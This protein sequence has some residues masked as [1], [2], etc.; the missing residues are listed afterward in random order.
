MTEKEIKRKEYLKAY[1]QANREKMLQQASEYQKTKTQ[2][3]QTKVY[4]E[5]TKHKR[6]LYYL[7][8]KDKI[9]Q[10]EKEYREA[11]KDKINERDRKN[12]NEKPIVRMS[13]NIRRNV[14]HSIKNSGFKKLTRTEQ[15]LGCTFDELKIYLESKFEDWMNW[16]NYGNPKDGILELNKTWDI[17][18]I[19]P[20]STATCEAD[21]IKLNHY[22]N[23]QPLCSYYNRN[24][25]RDNY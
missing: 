1:Y 19:I 12:W 17:D 13:S 25:K 18:H 22:T 2:K 14:L 8:N 10:R 7:A 6:K 15:I 11:N 21:I 3:G 20:L 23:L 9:K 4:D 16:D 24:I 5:E